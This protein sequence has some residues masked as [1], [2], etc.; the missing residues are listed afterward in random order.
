VRQAFAYAIDR[1]AIVKRLFGALGVEEAVNTINPPIQYR[2]SDPDAW[3]RYERDLDEV[4]TL[5]RG[6]GWRKNDA[7][8]WEKD[9][10]PAAFTIK[11]TTNDE[12]RALTERMLRNQLASAGFA[13]R[14]DNQTADELFLQTLPAGDY[15][16]SLYAQ[17]A[18]SMQPGLC[19]IFC[20]V[21]IPSP[22]NDQRGQNYGRVST[23]ADGPLTEV[24]MNLDENA[25]QQA[26]QQADEILAQEQV[27]LPLDPLPN[28][29]LWSKRIVGPVRDDPVLGM[30][31]NV[32]EW[33][34]R[35]P[36]RQ[37]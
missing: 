16:L 35:R 6:D 23:A 28:I 26:A 20:T 9:G 18:T 36:A 4:R 25:R 24:A 33:G 2:Y 29:M 27:A 10:V 17:I 34:L 5:M 37:S 31:A 7:G 30:F 15:E 19:S 13:L 32:H 14:A 12:R 11:S 8:I 1:D 22:S 3:A 21:N